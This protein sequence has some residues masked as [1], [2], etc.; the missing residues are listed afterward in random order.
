M[1]PRHEVETPSEY[2]PKAEISYGMSGSVIPSNWI[3]DSVHHHPSTRAADGVD[4]SI[5]SSP[6]ILKD[7][8]WVVRCRSIYEYVVSDSTA[9]LVCDRSLE[10]VSVMR[11]GM[12][13]LDPMFHVP[14]TMNH[15]P[16]L[17]CSGDAF[18]ATE[19]IV[20][21]ARPLKGESVCLM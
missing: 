3:H 12:L 10:G 7:S 20:S 8:K 15:P 11:P 1:A 9:I 5:I 17:Q 2:Q 13:G 6:S 19:P 21:C 4:A 18:T 14:W 16:A